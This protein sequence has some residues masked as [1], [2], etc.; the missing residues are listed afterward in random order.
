MRD[1]SGPLAGVSVSVKGTAVSALSDSEGRF[2]IAASAGDILVFSYVGYQT[3]EVAVSGSSANAFLVSEAQSLQE[4]V[5]NAGY[6]SVSESERT[7]SI[8]RITSTEISS[9]PVANM[10]ATMQG[11]MPG[12]RITQDSGVPGGGFNIEIRGRNSLRSAGNNPLYII[13][14][15]PYASDPIGTSSTSHVLGGS[16]SPLNSIS[17]DN[18]ES[19]EVLK[20]ADATAIYGSRGANGVVL[21]TTKRGRAGAMKFSLGYSR[22]LGTVTRMQ[23][24]MDTR[25]YISVRKQAFANDNISAYPA[26][27][28]DVNGTWDPDR[29]TDWQEV[30]LGG[31][32]EFTSANASVSGGNAS[33]QFL[34]S[35]NFLSQSSVFPGSHLYKKAN[36]MATAG[37]VSESGRFRAG[38][39]AA[40]TAQDNSQPTADLTREAIS[41]A[42]NAPALHLPDGSLNWENGTF[43]NP[44]RNLEG[45]FS[46]R[47]HD[48]VASANLSYALFTGLDAKLSLGFSDLRH[49]ESNT[50]PSTAQNPAFGLTSSSSILFLGNTGRQSHI[51][52]PQLNYRASLGSA[53]LDFLLGGTFQG[54]KGLQLA[55]R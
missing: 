44:L 35:G 27:A 9:Q 3:L 42:P 25:Q 29:Y 38:F 54:Q 55:Q 34:L 7:G 50:S 39:S 43:S 21:V 46:A 20:D 31:T 53:R 28:Y 45:K 13:D 18:I 40:Y 37:H 24:L 1:S 51:M 26:S 47:T 11:R 36:F 12:V 52:E 5:V 14:G 2:P 4:V 8:S 17:P 32:A 23:D 48:L 22:G 10:L 15:V 30:L 33:S 16:T 41:L 19:I 6:Y 49:A